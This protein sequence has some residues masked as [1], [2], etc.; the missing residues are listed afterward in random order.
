[1]LIDV[2][3][4]QWFL[5][6]LSVFLFVGPGIGIL[7]ILR[8]NTKFRIS[9]LYLF[10]FVLSVAF[11]SIFLAYLRFFKVTVLYPWFVYI[12]S[13][14]AWVIG[15]IVRGKQ[16]YK[17][18]L[19]G[20]DMWEVFLVLALISSLF[21]NT[22]AVRHMVVGLGSD[23][24]H[25]TLIT[26]L[27]IWNKGLPNNYSPAY[28]EIITF[29]YHFGFHTL[30]AVLS[31]LSGWEPR[32][33]V[34]VLAPILISLSGLAAAYFAWK[35]FR[36]EA[37]M[38]IAGIIPSLIGVFP[39]AMLEWG[40]YPQTLGLIILS[41][42]LAEYINV[43]DDSVSDKRKIFL[44]SILASGLSLT[45]YRV[46]I[47]GIMAV[48][49][50]EI[51]NLWRIKQ[52]LQSL[53]PRLLFNG[54]ISLAVIFFVWPWFLKVYLNQ[55]V[56]YPA[57]YS[58]PAESFFSILRLGTTALEYPTNGILISAFAL[59]GAWAIFK[60]DKLGS[61]IFIW[62]LLLLVSS[63]LTRGLKYTTI[64]PVTVIS[65]SYLPVAMMIG[66]GVYNLGKVKYFIDMKILLQSMFLL[67]CLWGAFHMNGLLNVPTAAYVKPEDLEAVNWIKQNTPEDACFMINTYRFEFSTNFIIGSD[68][69]GWLP[70]LAQRCVV[71][72]PMTSNIERFDH[73]NA[74]EKVVRI[75]ALRGELSS[76]NTIE[77]LK[78]YD[79]SYVYVKQ[80]ENQNSMINY[81]ESGYYELLFNFDNVYIYFLK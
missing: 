53:K 62:M 32:L 34:L 33:I 41:V 46:T 67:A 16:D 52:N 66:W 75:H 24:N 49:V 42:F 69:G 7:N 68:A 30:A 43:Q 6:I 19:V 9:L 38:S 2:Q 71:T 76:S 18:K 4:G 79:V 1:M 70:V 45:H 20:P 58:A 57:Q 15:L 47:M 26:Q 65:S 22:Y 44:I 64:D 3:A 63:W 28:P 21:I 80:D 36:S 5:L 48:M 74:L 37:A 50:W 77:I 17:I 59:C 23:S 54:F 61:W 10:A 56:G 51:F 31:L 35:V 55:F 29:N 27:I 72:Y 8:I 13:I 25:H 11:W 40:R 60:R 81:L 14:G 39:T 12:I 73:P 78:K